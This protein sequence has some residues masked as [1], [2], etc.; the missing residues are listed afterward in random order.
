[1]STLYYAATGQTVDLQDTSASTIAS[2]ATP[3]EELLHYTRSIPTFPWATVLVLSGLVVA[4]GAVAL[5]TRAH[6]R[7]QQ[8]R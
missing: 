2:N 6:R 5:E 4:G 8:G 3:P 7:H 1:M